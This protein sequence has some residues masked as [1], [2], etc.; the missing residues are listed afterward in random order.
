LLR[1]VLLL[2][3][4]VAI[5]ALPRDAEP[6]AFLAGA[7]AALLFLALEVGS[8]TLWAVRRS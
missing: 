2:A 8:E 6:G 1:N 7:G 3:A 4:A 5:V